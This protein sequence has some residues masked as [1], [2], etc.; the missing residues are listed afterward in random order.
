[1]ATIRVTIAQRKYFSK[2]YVEF[3]LIVII[4]EFFMAQDYK[5]FVIIFTITFFGVY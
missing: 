2:N 3:V 4:V 1:M 5:N